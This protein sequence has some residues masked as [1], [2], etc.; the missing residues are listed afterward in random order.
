[1]AK[2]TCVNGHVTKDDKALKCSQCGADLP[3][4]RKRDIRPSIVGILIVCSILAILLGVMEGGTTTSQQAAP[5]AGQQASLPAAAE[6]KPTNDATIARGATQPPATRTPVPTQTLVPMPVVGAD[7]KIGDITW[8]VLS[9]KDA[10]NVIKSNNQF[11]KDATTSGTFIVARY[12]VTNGGSKEVFYQAP[13]LLDSAKRKFGSSTDV[14]FFIPDDERCFLQKLNPGI[15]K[16][17]QAAY[18]VPADAKGLTAQITGL[19]LLSGSAQ[20]DLG[21]DKAK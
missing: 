11:I 8:K 14:Y 10:G 7:V 18:E 15:T 3:P 4:V 20:V 13:D 5:A 12:Q 6:T 16:T 2:R 1:M 21:L 17:C 19:G 9:A